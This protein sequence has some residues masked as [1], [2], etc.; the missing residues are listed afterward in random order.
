MAWFF[1]PAN[2]SFS[3]RLEPWTTTFSYKG[4]YPSR[5]CS[6]RRGNFEQSI[7]RVMSRNHFLWA[8]YSNFAF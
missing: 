8:F 1:F 7:N 3:F 5:K 4:Y 2:R 6:Q